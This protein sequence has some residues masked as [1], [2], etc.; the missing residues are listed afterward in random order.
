[1]NLSLFFEDQG[2]YIHKFADS[3]IAVVGN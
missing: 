2:P 3:G 1:M